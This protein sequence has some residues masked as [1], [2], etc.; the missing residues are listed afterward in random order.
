M[1][2]TLCPY[3]KYHY[4]THRANCDIHC[5]HTQSTITVHTGQ[6]ET[7]TVPIHKV[8]LLYTQ[9]KMRHTLCPYTKY[10]YCTHRAKWD[11][12]CAHT[13]ST[14]TVHTGQNETYTVPIHKV[15]LL[16]TQGKMRHTLCPYTKY[17]YCTHRAKWDIHCAHTLST[18]TVHTGQNET[19][20]VPIH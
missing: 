18:I 5:A 14:I 17:H 20:T 15:P 9:G 19:Y 3:T 8:P 10:H 2:H 6:N 16:Y 11:I 7:Y 4:C 1:R 12:H 13:Q